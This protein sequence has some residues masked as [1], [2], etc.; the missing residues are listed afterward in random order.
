[1]TLSEWTANVL[2]QVRNHH[3]SEAGTPPRISDND[4]N[5]YIGYFENPYGEQAV[6]VFDRTTQTAA[7]YLGDAG[8]ETGHAVIDGLV[9]DLVLGAAELLWLQ[10]CWQAATGRR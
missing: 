4:P 8:W 3:T 9:P 5:R 1:M 7:V 6:F 2:L 10:A